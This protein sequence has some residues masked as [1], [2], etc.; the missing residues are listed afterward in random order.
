L[1]EIDVAREK[2]STDNYTSLTNLISYD[3]RESTST[4]VEVVH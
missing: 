4:G 3:C 2:H 1:V